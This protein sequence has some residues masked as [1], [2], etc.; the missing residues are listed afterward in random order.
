VSKIKLRKKFLIQRKNNFNSSNINFSLLNKILKK[1]KI[2]KTKRIGAYYPINYEIECF[3]II[4]KLEILG[5]KISLPVINKKNKMDFFEWSFDNPLRVGKFGIP[6]PHNTKKVYPDVLL[7]PLVAFDRYNFRLGYGGGYYDRYIKKISNIKK[8]IT[9]GL[10]FS[11][12]KIYKIPINETDEKLDFI[13]TE[14]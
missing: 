4:K 5:H 1:F 9:I 7:V 8:I 6:V 10:A 11:F 3:K 14:K 13:L 2:I 12:Q